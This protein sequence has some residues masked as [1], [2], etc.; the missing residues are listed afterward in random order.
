M[1]ERSGVL[2]FGQ[3]VVLAS[4]ERLGRLRSVVVA[5]PARQV[6]ALVVDR[7]LWQPDALVPASR[8][9]ALATE[10]VTLDDGSVLPALDSAP[11]GPAL[12]AALAQADLVLSAD[13]PVLVQEQT[14]VQASDGMAGHL[15]GLAVADPGWRLTALIVRLQGE[16]RPVRVPAEA[17]AALASQTAR[18]TLPQAELRRAPTYRPDDAIRAEVRQA[19][20]ADELIRRFDAAAIDVDVRDGVVR[21]RG[22]VSDGRNRERAEELARRVAGVR[23]VV[24]ELITDAELLLDLAQ[25]LARDERTNTA[26]IGTNSLHGIVY[27]F[28]EVR[29]PAVRAAAEE[30]AA[31]RPHVRMVVNQLV[32]PGLPPEEQPLALPRPGQNV[33]AGNELIGRVEQVVISPRSRRVTAMVVR[34]ERVDAERIDPL[35]GDAPTEERCLVLPVSMIDDIG[36]LELFLNVDAASVWNAPTFDADDYVAPDAGWEPPFPYRREEVLLDLQRRRARRADLLVAERGWLEAVGEQAGGWIAVGDM[37]TFPDGEAGLVDRVLL[38]PHR[39][40]ACHLVVRA[41]IFFEQDSVLPVE[42][43][44]SVADGTIV[45][46]VGSAQLAA[47]PAYT[48]P[49]GAARPEQHPEISA[50]GGPLRLPERADGGQ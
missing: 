29:S 37:V 13:E 17:L 21:L 39:G 2:V 40:T 14:M 10:E 7:G 33:F 49:D 3:P 9:A 22:Y 19:L 27:L 25:A 34:G 45:V 15:V 32:V 31:R 50:E 24:N 28:G 44:V 41:G 48:S 38:D 11:D 42:W 1:N 18:L 6:V 47:L 46:D 20:R 16:R 26:A 43:I 30:I 23:R 5:W 35:L 12:R 8:I 4:G 36:A